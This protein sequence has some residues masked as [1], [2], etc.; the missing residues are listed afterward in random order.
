M[1]KLRRMSREQRLNLI[2]SVVRG[3][4]E[5][6]TTG[7]IARSMN[8]TNSPYLRELLLTLRDEGF[9]SSE[10]I[11]TEDFGYAVFWKYSGPPRVVTS[12]PVDLTNDV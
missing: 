6:M 12:T 11:E 1:P 3:S 4:A 5:P 8:L 7:D 9:L 2:V 10:G